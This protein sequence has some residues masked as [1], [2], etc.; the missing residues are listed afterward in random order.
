MSD[1]SVT[2]SDSR[3]DP[4]KVRMIAQ[5][6]IRNG[7]GQLFNYTFNQAL[8]ANVPVEMAIDADNGVV[9]SFTVTQTAFPMSND[10]RLVNNKQYYF[11]ILAYGYNNYKE[12]D[13]NDP[14]KLNGQKKP[15]LAGRKNIKNYT[16]IPHKTVNGMVMNSN[17]GD[18][19]SISRI[20]GNGNGGV[21]LEFTEESIELLLSKPPAGIT[22]SGDT[23][24]YGDDD[25]PLI[26]NPVYK[27]GKG[28]VYIKVIDPLNVKEASYLLKFDTVFYRVVY[29]NITN[30]DGMVPGG[31]TLSITATPGWQIID[32]E[33]QHVYE[34]DTS[35]NIEYEQLFPDLGISITF[36]PI[37][38][39]GPYTVGKMADAE[40]TAVNAVPAP[41]NGLI[42]ATIS[43]SDSSQR[44]LS[45]I[46]DQDII[47]FPMNW[48]RSGTYD[49][50]WAS[51]NDPW[52]PDEVYEKMIGGTW[53]PYALCAYNG[54]DSYG[55]APAFGEA[56]GT[57]KS[58]SNKM[59]NVYSVEVV[60]TP[61]KSKW[62]RSPVI[63]MCNDPLLSVGGASKFALRRSASLDKNG[64]PSGWPADKSKSFSKDDPN[65]IAPYGM[66]WFPGYAVN[67]ETGERLNIIFGEDSNLPTEN[68]RDMLFNP[69]SSD[70]RRRDDNNQIITDPLTPL[71]GGKHYVYV[72]G[73]GEYVRSSGA[74]TLR[75]KFS[76]YDA[77][78]GLQMALDT[79]PPKG[80]SFYQ[81]YGSLIY[82]STQYVNIPLAVDDVPWLANEVKVRISLV[83]PY[84]RYYANSP[85]PS[86]AGEGLNKHYP[87]Y[88]FSTKGI[89]TTEYSADKAETDLDL[90]AVVPN[91]YY[92]FAVANGYESVPLENLVKIINLPEKA[93]V[94]IYNVN[95]TRIRQLT[96]DD[97]V[98]FLDWDLKNHAGIPIAGGVYLFHVK[99]EIKNSERIVKWF[100]ALRVEDFN[101]F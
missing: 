77:G 87:L 70:L 54:Q 45:G 61:D 33:T 63:E 98:T 69:T 58:L 68:G 96:K 14:T 8:G 78:R 83:R 38:Q 32:Q 26:Y 53:A 42:E 5:Y 76:A 17:Y 51:S 81:I 20:E 101:E 92:A 47:G 88:E 2:I 97:P 75:F 90:V 39:A 89:A 21:A 55:A 84:N 43:F 72:M 12:Y 16:A 46:A 71:F 93:T 22:E 62:T 64:N 4:D 67:L 91:P 40:N 57:S 15:Y 65:Y 27:N 60:F 44:W 49:D 80:D 24:A 34:A 19:P 100:G 85:L 1:A 18:G 73:S 6:D 35:T 37:V 31:D 48:I 30:T 99:D 52:D 41:N 3:D 36:G 28:P 66:S 82:A 9:H 29:D 79:L 50:D 7:V 10:S 86:S 94:T 56:A 59:K 11:S 23:I 13:Q 95:G 74:D 25:Y